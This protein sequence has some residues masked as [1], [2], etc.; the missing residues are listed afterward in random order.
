M[1]AI[2]EEVFDNLLIIVFFGVIL[3]AVYH[4]LDVGTYKREYSRAVQSTS[5]K[6]ILK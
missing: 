5:F 4:Y 2:L 6:P 3:W 1:K